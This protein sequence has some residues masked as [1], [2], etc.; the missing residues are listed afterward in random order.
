MK[1]QQYLETPIVFLFLQNND[2]CNSQRS[3]LEQNVTNLALELPD[4]VPIYLTLV[5]NHKKW[6]ADKKLKLLLFAN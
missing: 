2:G 1:T 6:L 3:F 5:H 4:W